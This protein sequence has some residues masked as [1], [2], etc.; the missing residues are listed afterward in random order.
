MLIFS[1]STDAKY[2]KVTFEK[3][4]YSY[5]DMLY[6]TALGIVKNPADAEDV[7]QNA[8][9]KISKNLGCIKDVGSKSTAAFLAVITKNSAYDFL[10]VRNKYSEIPLYDT[11][12]PVSDDIIEQISL[13]TDY[14]KLVAIIKSIPSP[15]NEVLFLH[16]VYELSTKET[17]HIL[18][19]KTST[20][21]QQL[22]RGK[23]LL[24]E[25]T[26]GQKNE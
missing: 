14:E 6:A 19:R 16:F 10:R 4:Y 9:I 11:D 8:F 1:F 13:K 7:L 18:S 3:L 26:G 21:K 2:E 5:R 15:Y 24:L 20:V 22:V 17:A 25:K 23:K 12:L